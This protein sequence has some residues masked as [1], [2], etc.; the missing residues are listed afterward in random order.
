MH[1]RTVPTTCLPACI[2]RSWSPSPTGS[3]W[4]C[5]RS[6]ATRSWLGLGWWTSLPRRSMQTQWAGGPARKPCSGPLSSPETRRWCATSPAEPT[7]SA[8]R[9]C[10]GTASTCGLT[11]RRS[12]TTGTCRASSLA[13][14]GAK[15]RLATRAPG[16]FCERTHQDSVTPRR[17]KQS[18]ST[19]S[20]G[21]SDSRSTRP[22]VRAVADR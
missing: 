10:C 14:A 16:S 15:A 9:S 12:S 1:N 13:R 11:A 5:Q 2:R 3:S 18:S 21:S 6:W 19:G 7:R 17:R 22:S 4:C 20:I 8:T